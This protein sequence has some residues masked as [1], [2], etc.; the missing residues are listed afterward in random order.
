MKHQGHGNLE[1]NNRQITSLTNNFCDFA[2]PLIFGDLSLIHTFQRG[3]CGCVL[4]PV[5]WT[6]SAH[7]LSFPRAGGGVAVFPHP[8][9]PHCPQILKALCS[10][11]H[12]V[13]GVSRTCLGLPHEPEFSSPLTS[14]R[15]AW[16]ARG[17]GASAR[18]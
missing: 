1:S 4:L 3:Q 10:G 5:V 16:E 11:H 18:G 14:G 7:T 12:T 9:A 17:A 2:S 15:T 6:L 8:R 13:V